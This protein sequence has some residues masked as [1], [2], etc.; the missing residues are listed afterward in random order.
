MGG[1]CIKECC[2]GGH[3]LGEVRESGFNTNGQQY[4]LTAGGTDEVRV[5]EFR[6][7][8]PDFLDKDFP[9]TNKSLLGKA[10]KSK[11]AK[12]AALE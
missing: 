4:Q 10:Y 5:S 3:E 11:D 2:E 9:H 12:F 6:N 1:N 8:Y 7:K